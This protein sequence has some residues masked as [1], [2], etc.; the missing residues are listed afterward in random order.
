MGTFDGATT[1]WFEASRGELG[2]AAGREETRKHV[3][4]SF[5]GCKP[6]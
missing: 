3:P 2:M 4:D 6:P 1:E 5:G